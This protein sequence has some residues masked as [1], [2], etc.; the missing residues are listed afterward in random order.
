MCVDC[1]YSQRGN[2]RIICR[3][4]HHRQPAGITLP[5]YLATGSHLRLDHAGGGPGLERR[6]RP[7]PSVDAWTIHR[8]I[9]QGMSDARTQESWVRAS[10]AKRGLSNSARHRGQHRQPPG[11]PSR[12]RTSSPVPLPTAAGRQAV[13]SRLSPHVCPASPRIP[14]I[15]NYDEITKKET[16]SP[17]FFCPFADSFFFAIVFLNVFSAHFFRNLFSKRFFGASVG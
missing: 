7:D 8:A 3:C 9:N 11:T 4:R 6:F 17:F 10:W 1:H 14:R 15:Q 5:K 16:T 2:E 12:P 13:R